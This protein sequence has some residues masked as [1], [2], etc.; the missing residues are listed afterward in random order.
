MCH[1]GIIADRGKL[2]NLKLICSKK[3][4]QNSKQLEKGKFSKL[5]KFSWVCQRS[6]ILSLIV[7]SQLEKKKA[8]GKT[9]ISVSATFL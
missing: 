8:G 5:G 2:V 3:Y 1:V 7:I 4:K 9:N 6:R